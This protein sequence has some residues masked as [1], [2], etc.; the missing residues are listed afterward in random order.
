MLDIVASLWRDHHLQPLA[1]E[2]RQQYGAE[3]SVKTTGQPI[4]PLAA[5]NDQGAVGG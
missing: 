1:D 3:L 5:D 4:T 2:W